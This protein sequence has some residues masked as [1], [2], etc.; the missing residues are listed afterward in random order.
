[1][2]NECMNY[3][4]LTGRPEEIALFK[5]SYLVYNEKIEDYELDFNHITPIPI[6]CQDD[7]V[8]RIENWGNKWDGTEAYVGAYDDEIY[9]DVAT[10]WSPCIP[11]VDKLIRLCPGLEVDYK[12]YEPGNAFVGWRYHIA[13]ENPDE[14]ES[15]EIIIE[16]DP[17]RYWVHMF[18][19]EYENFDWL[20]EN[21]HDLVD[22]E[23]VNEEDVNTL[24]L[25]I[26][27]GT[28]SIEEI[29]EYC[30]E[31]TIL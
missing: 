3:I 31:K 25:M 24:E 20:L 15:E 18:N 6:D 21:A 17:Y 2:A 11:I 29:V 19:E 23:E 4:R 5:D 27:Q 16:N 12:Y 10:A 26:D 13:Y 30:I 9:I 1:M 28:S 7:Y 14:D 8:F 22:S